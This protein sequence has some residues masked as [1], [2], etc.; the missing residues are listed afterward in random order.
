MKSRGSPSARD[1]VDWTLA[2]SIT[3]QIMTKSSSE[4]INR[5]IEIYLRMSVC[6]IYESLFGILLDIF[7]LVA[8]GFRYSVS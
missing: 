7:V 8:C 5:L 2:I 3:L 4:V 6:N 1:S